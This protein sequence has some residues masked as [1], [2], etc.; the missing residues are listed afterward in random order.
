LVRVSCPPLEKWKSYIAQSRALYKII[1]VHPA[2]DIRKNDLKILKDLEGFAYLLLQI[3][4]SA[5]LPLQK[6]LIWH[7]DL[8][9]G[10]AL[11]GK[12]IAHFL[13]GIKLIIVDKEVNIF[14]SYL[15]SRVLN[16]NLKNFDC[17]V[18]VPVIIETDTMSRLRLRHF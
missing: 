15:T 17:Q 13:E 16:G 11:L 9:I 8:H 1:Y 12:N 18:L 3:P 7:Q 2:G 6:V 14:L 5:T 4:V 10:P